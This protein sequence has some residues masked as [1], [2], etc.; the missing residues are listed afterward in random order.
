MR[1]PETLVGF[2]FMIDMNPAHQVE[3]QDDVL[4]ALADVP[5]VKSAY[6]AMG[7]RAYYIVEYQL[8]NDE[9]LNLWEIE[10]ALIKARDSVAV[11]QDVK[12]CRKCKKWTPHQEYPLDFKC[13]VCGEW[14]D[15][16]QLK[17]RDE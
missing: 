10:Q 7:A 3:Q 16:L 15:S 2:F 11:G 9:L 6:D 5:N 8:T 12:K 14:Y 17:D 1:Y 13:R 4:M